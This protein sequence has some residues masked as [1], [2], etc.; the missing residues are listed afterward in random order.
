MFKRGLQWF[1]ATRLGVS[2]TRSLVVPLDQLAL[3]ATRGHVSVTMGTAPIAVLISTG[4]RS[5]LQRETPLQYFTDGDD[6][7]LAASNFGSGRNPGWYYNLAAH[8]DCDLRVGAAMGRFVARE[9]A[10]ED[11]D[12]LFDLAI[13]LYPG[14]LKY[15]GRT[16]GI[17]QIRMMRLTPQ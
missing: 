16:E 15:A 1:F 4:A 11:R 2:L 10:N 9:V 3:R 5:G 17:R 6:V 7:V 13:K 8:P 14:Y 12:R